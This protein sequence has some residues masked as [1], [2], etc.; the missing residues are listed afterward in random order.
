MQ[1]A[2]L[3]QLTGAELGMQ[4]LKGVTSL[5]PWGFSLLGFSLTKGQFPSLAST[6]F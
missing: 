3:T 2:Q 1:A 6:L 5:G 4:R